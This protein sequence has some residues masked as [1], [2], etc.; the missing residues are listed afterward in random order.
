[1]KSSAD[2]LLANLATVKSQADL[3]TLYAKAAQLVRSSEIQ[4]ATRLVGDYRVGFRTGQFES[5]GKS[6]ICRDQKMLNLLTALESGLDGIPRLPYS[7]PTLQSPSIFDAM[8]QL[9]QKFG[10]IQ[11]PLGQKGNFSGLWTPDAYFLLILSILI[12]AANVWGAIMTG[13]SRSIWT[14]DEVTVWQRKLWVLSALVWDYGDSGYLAVPLNCNQKTTQY[15]DYVAELCELKPVANMANVELEYAAKK[16]GP[17]GPYL[18]ER[19]RQAV[20]DCTHVKLYRLNEN[21]RKLRRSVVL[22][23]GFSEPNPPEFR[24]SP[25]TVGHRRNA[26]RSVG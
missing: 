3:D 20:P 11:S 4:Q 7:A 12:D 19:I 23:I 26:F 1:M 18:I 22:R 14:H 13:R 16:L 25:T 24:S 2:D 6:V 9:A 5:E 8:A 10:I 17:D 21:A 15:A